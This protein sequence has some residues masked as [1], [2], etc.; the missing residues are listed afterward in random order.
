MFKTGQCDFPGN[1]TAT[2]P[3]VALGNQDFQAVPDQERS[4]NQCVMAAAG[5]DDINLTLTCSLD[6]HSGTGRNPVD[7]IFR[8]YADYPSQIFGVRVKTHGDNGNAPK[9]QMSFYSDPKYLYINTRL[10]N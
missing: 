2:H 8:L 10:S 4:T 6:R 9:Y 1:H 7:F 5:N 3:V